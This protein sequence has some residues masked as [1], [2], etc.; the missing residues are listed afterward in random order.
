MFTCAHCHITYFHTGEIEKDQGD[1]IIR[2][3]CGAK[4]IVSTKPINNAPVPILILQIL[5]YR[6]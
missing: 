2:C 1:W 3:P 5:G 4:N 6:D